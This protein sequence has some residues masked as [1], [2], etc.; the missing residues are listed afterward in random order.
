MWRLFVPVHIHKE[1][2][3]DAANYQ[4]KC[5]P[6]RSHLQSMIWHGDFELRGRIAL[7]NRHGL[8]FLLVYNQIREPGQ[9]TEVADPWHDDDSD[10]AA[11]LQHA[12][13][14]PPPSTLLLN[15]LVP[16]RIVVR[17]ISPAEHL[18]LPDPLE[19]NF[20]GG[21]YE[22]CAKLSQWGHHCIVRRCCHQSLFF[23]VP[24]AE[25]HPWSQ[26]GHH[27]VFC[28]D[29]PTD[30]QGVFMHSQLHRL[31]ELTI[32]RL[33]CSLGYDRAVVLQI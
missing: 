20:P 11:L 30:L 16:H 4:H 1:A 9:A 33:V 27:Y 6:E 3:I 13:K 7:R 2:V 24:A 31:D 25:E 10:D 22:V 23:C 19:V 18:P 12:L 28:H 26:G 5:Y 21:E 29:D 17:L 32:M 14:K 8:S 15:E